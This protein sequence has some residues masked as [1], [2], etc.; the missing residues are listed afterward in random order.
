MAKWINVYHTT[1]LGNA[2]KIIK[3]GWNIQKQFLRGQLYGRGIYFWEKEDDAKMFGELYY[4]KSGY[5]ILMEEV[6]YRNILSYD[7]KMRVPNNDDA[8]LFSKQM[9]QRGYELV[10]IRSAYMD[11]TTMKQAKGKAYVWLVDINIPYLKIS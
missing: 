1:G 4:S 9:I 2:D 7:F 10:E 6:P 5:D 11:D 8:D 3:D